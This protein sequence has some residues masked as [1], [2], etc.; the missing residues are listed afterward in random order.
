VQTA[1]IER[2]HRASITSPFRPFTDDERLLVTRQMQEAYD[3]FV[4]RVVEG[5]SLAPDAVRAAAEGRV[6]TGGQALGLKLVDRI[7]TLR[8]AVER[9]RELSGA[10][11][12]PAELYPA[13]KSLMEML[14]EQ[15][16]QQE[17]STTLA[18]LRRYPAGRRALA[19]GGLLLG[20]RVLAYAPIEIE[21]R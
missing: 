1:V 14:G 19:L 11:G 17:T 18:L 4:E 15:L 8:D 2:G 16:T 12:A 20:N 13:P 21:V 5:R 3:L 7:G 6:W 10:K 9:A